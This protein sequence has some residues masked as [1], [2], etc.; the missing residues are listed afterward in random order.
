MDYIRPNQVTSPQDY[1]SN[2]RVLHDGGENSFSIAMI[3]WEGNDCFA[4]RWNVARREWDDPEKQNENRHCVG[5]PSSH[6]Y[7]V[8]FVLPDEIIDTRSGVWNIIN[9]HRKK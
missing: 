1:I 2:V 9:K 7:P 4:I 5:M 3:E 8:W 6:G